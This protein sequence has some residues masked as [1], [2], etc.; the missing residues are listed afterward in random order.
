MVNLSEDRVAMDIKNL[1]DMEC[2]AIEAFRCDR[3]PV[4]KV[5][6]RLRLPLRRAESV[7]FNLCEIRGILFLD[8][9]GLYAVRFEAP[10]KPASEWG[11][12]QKARQT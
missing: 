11:K 8:D 10:L 4:R 9:D 12:P 2:R 7:V 6:K 1:T 3:L 5:A